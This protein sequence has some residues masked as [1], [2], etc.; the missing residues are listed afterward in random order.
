MC[1][2]IRLK[3]GKI[4]RKSVQETKACELERKQECSVLLWSVSR[5][6]DPVT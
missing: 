2:E 1:P 6:T 5:A 3:N 4:G